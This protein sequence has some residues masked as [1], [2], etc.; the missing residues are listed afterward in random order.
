MSKEPE[1]SEAV[2]IKEK[3]LNRFKQSWLEQ[4]NDAQSINGKTKGKH[5]P[6]APFGLNKKQMEEADRRATE[7]ITPAGNGFSPKPI[8][9]NISKLNSHHWKEVN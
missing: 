5:L 8:F 6:A 2:R 9:A 3:E 1:D 7:I 4:K